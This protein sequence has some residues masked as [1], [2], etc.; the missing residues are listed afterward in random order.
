VSKE[1]EGMAVKRT[2]QRA[3]E[4]VRKMLKRMESIWAVI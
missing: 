4:R 2:P 3:G 1:N